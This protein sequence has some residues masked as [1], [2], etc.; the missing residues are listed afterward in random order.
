MN[1]KASGSS[2]SMARNSTANGNLYE[3]AA[4]NV[5]NGTAFSQSDFD[6]TVK[7]FKTESESNSSGIY[8]NYPQRLSNQKQNLLSRFYPLW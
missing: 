6:T 4:N 8:N 2:F 3:K 5:L 7:L 1:D